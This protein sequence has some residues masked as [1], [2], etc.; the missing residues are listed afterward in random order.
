MR[1]HVAVCSHLFEQTHHI[2]LHLSHLL[3]EPDKKCKKQNSQGH[4]TDL[5]PDILACMLSPCLSTFHLHSR[6]QIPFFFNSCYCER[7]LLPRLLQSETS[8]SHLLLFIPAKSQ[9]LR[10]LPNSFL[11]ASS[12]RRANKTSLNIPQNKR[13][14]RAV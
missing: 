6:T 13:H 5:V 8:F 4:Q 9:K 7:Q 14:L 10:C 3:Q 12:T 1:L 11:Q 2:S